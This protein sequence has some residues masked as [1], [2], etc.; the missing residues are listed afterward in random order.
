MVYTLS[1]VSMASPRGL[2]SLHPVSALANVLTSP[3]GDTRRRSPSHSTTRPPDAIL[4]NL[5][6]APC[7]SPLPDLSLPANSIIDPTRQHMNKRRNGTAQRRQTIGHALLDGIAGIDDG[8]DGT[9][10]RTHG[11]LIGR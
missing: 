4:L 10:E 11:E 9:R 2:T 7:P 1:R 3:D 6:L 8:V 5:A